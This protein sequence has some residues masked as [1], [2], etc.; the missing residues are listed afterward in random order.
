MN[1]ASRRNFV[2]GADSGV[3][4][5]GGAGERQQF[6][7][8]RSQPPAH[9]SNRLNGGAFVKSAQHLTFG[10]YAGAQSVTAAVDFPDQVFDTLYVDGISFQKID[11]Q[12]RI[13]VDSSHFSLPSS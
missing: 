2:L 10:E 13:P 4:V 8:R 5:S 3:T 9:F 11:E 12:H 6:D 7:G 1:G